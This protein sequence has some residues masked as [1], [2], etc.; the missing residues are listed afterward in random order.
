MAVEDIERDV[1]LAGFKCPPHIIQEVASGNPQQMIDYEIEEEERAKPT[2][3]SPA[4]NFGAPIG[5]ETT[6]LSPRYKSPTIDPPK[7]K[8]N[9]PFIKAGPPHSKTEARG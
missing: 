4:K 7:G 1:C 8:A 3:S 2:T 9:A 6:E 5:H